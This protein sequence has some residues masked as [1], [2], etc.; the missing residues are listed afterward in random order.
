MV[1]LKIAGIMFAAV[2]IGMAGCATAPPPDMGR[3]TV[4]PLAAAHSDITFMLTTGSRQQ[5]ACAEVPVCRNGGG[6]VAGKPTPIAVQV[7]RVARVLQHGVESLYPDLALRIP[8]FTDRGF[9]VYIAAGDE[10]GSVS[11]ASG[12]IALN[13]AF[14]V[15][16]PYDDWLAFVIAREMGHVIARHHEENSSVSI[17]TSVIMNILIPG[18]GLLKS[19]ASTIGAELVVGSKRDRQASEAD[20]IALNLLQ[21]AGFGLHDVALSLVIASAGLDD[22]SWSQGFRKS[23]DKLIAGARGSRFA[24]ASDSAAAGSAR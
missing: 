17:A 11:S 13:A 18:S 24:D 2:G 1:H 21:A 8:G 20:A 7:Q 9:D 15:S 5:A 3:T 22:G 16:L 4:L 6:A 23:S 10:P 14:G 12:R 19:A